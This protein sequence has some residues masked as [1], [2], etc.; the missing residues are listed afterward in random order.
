MSRSFF[1]LVPKGSFVMGSKRGLPIEMPAHDVNIEADFFHRC[2]SRHAARRVIRGGAWDMDV[3]RCRSA[4]R[5]CE[6]ESISSKKIGFRI[7]IEI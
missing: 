7:L 4:Y 3:F 5:S 6:G 2:I 1:V